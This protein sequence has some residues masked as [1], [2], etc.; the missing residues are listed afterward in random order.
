MK[1]NKK[2][3]QENVFFETF[4]KIYNF[5]SLYITKKN[6][7]LILIFLNTHSMMTLRTISRKEM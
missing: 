2:S 4:F 6:K 1:Q 7:K 3:K 5:K